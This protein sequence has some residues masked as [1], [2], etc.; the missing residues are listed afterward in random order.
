VVEVTVYQQRAT[1]GGEPTAGIV[2][3]AVAASL[4]LFLGLSWL[5]FQFSLKR[6][7][8]N[9]WQP[10][11]QNLRRVYAY[12]L[13]DQQPLALFPTDVRE[14]VFF[15]EAI[16]GFIANT[17][18]VYD[19]LREFT[20]NTAHELQTPLAVVL[21]K[22]ELLLKR[23]GLD[24]GERQDVLEIKQ[25]VQRLSAL[26]KALNLL[27]RVRALHHAGPLPAEPVAVSELL[28][29][30]LSRYEE[31]LDYR[32]LTVAWGAPA[33]PWQLQTNRELLG[34][35]LDNL[36]R[37]AIQHNLLGGRLGVQLLPAGGLVLCNTGAAPAT[38]APDP[39]RRYHSRSTDDG[40]LGLGLAIV[41]AISETLGLACRYQFEPEA[42]GGWHVFTLTPR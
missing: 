36:V 15:N 6:V 20:E 25:T 18:R 29:E 39:F 27:S 5:L 41:Q 23:P 9:L 2:L 40:H 38:A 22:T 35:L 21:A 11:Y 12:N 17:Q 28:A 7:S 32:A 1:A 14:F 26:Q 13:R 8:F 16:T 10:F 31:L 19:E 24:A 37:N 3:G 4:L 30:T 42:A 34:I 33:P